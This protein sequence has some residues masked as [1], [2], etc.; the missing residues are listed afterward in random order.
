MAL[1]CA[2]AWSLSASVAECDITPD[3]TQFKVPMA[4][5]GARMGKPS[6]GV[7][8]PIRAKILVLKT[9][10]TKVAI[11]TTDLRSIT[12]ELKSKTL[13]KATGLGYD[14]GN[15]MM[16]ASHSHSGPS[17]YAEKFWQIQ[18]GKYDPQIVE[19]MSEKMAKA[20]RDADDPKEQIVD[21]TFGLASKRLEGFTKNRRW[22]YDQ[23]AREAA[24][25]TPAL[26]PVLTVLRFNNIQSTSGTRCGV[27]FVNFPTHPTILGADNMQIS[28][29]WPGV[30][31]RELESD[32]GLGCSLTLY[33]NGAEGDQSPITISDPD[34]FKRM[35]E[36]GKRL[37]SE[38][39]ALAMIIKDDGDDSDDKI[40]SILIEPELPE[41]VFSEGAQKGPNTMM[42]QAALD[43]LPRKAE[44][45]VIRIGE[46]A[47]V[48]LPGEPICEVGIETRRQVEAAGAKHTIII[49]LA[50]DY[51]GYILNDKEYKHGGYE[52][53]SRSYYGPGLGD[54]IAHRAGE[55]AKKLWAEKRE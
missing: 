37:A 2:E 8:D 20:L 14:A 22:E 41:I 55:A 27:L 18:F 34:A 46:I 26:D 28:A 13:E 16:C 21:A 32:L 23:L 17:I 44:I 39:K 25:E 38:T 11:I 1:Y 52:V 9:D 40:G 54:F 47:L 24:G 51:I 53:D 3:V 15:V 36:F 10:D 45:Q 43:A 4:G 35:E 42:S 5:Y 31:Q 12:P 49:G 29:E 30:L 50:N 6:T 19:I 48:G 7:H 33:S